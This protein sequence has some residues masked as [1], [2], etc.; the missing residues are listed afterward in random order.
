MAGV[1]V[2]GIAIGGI[3][4]AKALGKNSDANTGHCTGNVCDA[5]GV[6]LRQDAVHA[7]NISTIAFVA[8]GVAIA[9]GAVLVHG[10]L[11]PRNLGRP[12]DGRRQLRRGR[13]RHLVSGG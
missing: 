12:G 4:G 6:S 7:G 1:G 10:S 9:G 11:E 3:F 2:V 8:G 13:T 5:T